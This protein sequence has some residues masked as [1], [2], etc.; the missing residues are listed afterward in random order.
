MMTANSLSESKQQELLL[1]ER[2]ANS[3]W[4]KLRRNKSAML[5]LVLIVFVLLVSIFGPFLMSRDPAAMDFLQINAKPGTNGF[6][7]GSDSLGR[8]VLTRLVYGGR[9]SLLVA[10]GGMA[11]GAV[12]GILIGLVSGYSGGGVDAVLMRIMDGM[13]AFP[14]VLLALMLMTVLGAGMGNVILAIGIASVP[15]Y[16]RMTRGQVLMVKNEDYIKAVKALGASHSRVLFSHLLPNVVSSLIVYATLNVAGAILT[17]ASL[18][19]LGMGITPPQVSWGSILKDGQ[20]CLQSAG[21]VAIF[22][23]LAILITVLGFNLLG[24]GIRDVLDPKMK[25]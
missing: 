20:E 7:L 2:K 19:F 13:S 25:K 9:I 24:D 15:G 8:D 10:V 18:S 12:I 11:V 16:A 5:G 1:R 21:H 3:A 23:G 6:L 17:E 14:F 4:K 22:S